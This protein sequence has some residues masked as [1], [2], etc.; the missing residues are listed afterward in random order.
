MAEKIPRMGSG[1]FQWNTAGWFGGQIGSTIWILIVGILA[2]FYN[3]PAGL[4]VISFFLLPNA[5]GYFLWHN[6]DRLEPYPAVQ[7]L[8]ASI[9]LFSFF[10]FLAY[11][12]SGLASQLGPK[13]VR[14]YRNFYFILL[15]YPGLMIQFYFLNRGAKNK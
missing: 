7:C 12:L 10:T 6:R 3:I 2:L 15:L 4:L 8:M 1:S 5:I 14:S 11:D 9:F 13:S